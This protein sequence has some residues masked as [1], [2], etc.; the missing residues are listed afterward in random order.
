MHKVGTV[1]CTYFALSPFQS[2]QRL[3]VRLCS[4]MWNDY[5]WDNQDISIY[6][7]LH[8]VAT[9]DASYTLTFWYQPY[10]YDYENK[11]FLAVTLDN[12]EIARVPI[13]TYS[14][15]WIPFKVA[16]VRSPSANPVLKL[17]LVNEG[18]FWMDLGSEVFVDSVSLVKEQVD[19][20]VQVVSCVSQPPP[21]PTDV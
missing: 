21:L 10:Y 6:Q 7:T 1:L 12:I 14:A 18:E 4:I 15:T 9:T 13:S 5:N 8:N 2:R 17:K 11:S 20:V 16:G 3:M 19:P